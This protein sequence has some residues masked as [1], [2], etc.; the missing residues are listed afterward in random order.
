MNKRIKVLI[1]LALFN[2]SSI[3]VISLISNPVSGQTNGNSL[4]VF[5][6]FSLI[7]Y[8]NFQHEDLDVNLIN[9]SLSSAKWNVKGIELNFSSIK[10][11]EEVVSIEEGGSS[12]KSI[13]KSVK[14]YGVQLNI[15]QDLLLLGVYI[16]GYLDLVPKSPVYVQINGYDAMNH[17]P[18]STIYGN[19]IPIN[20]SSVPNWYLQKFT[21]PISLSKGYYYLV[22]NG[23]GYLPS[24]NSKYNWYLNE[25][26]SIHNFTY[27]SKFDGLSWSIEAQGKPFR[28]KLVQRTEKSFSPEAI[29]MNIEI[30]GSLYNVS[31]GVIPNTGYIKV[32]NVNLALNDSNLMIPISHNQTVSI[33]FNA[34]YNLVLESLLPSYGTS[35]ISTNSDIQWSILPTISREFSNYSV[36]FNFPNNWYNILIKR[37]NIDIT[38]QIEVNQLNH[39]IYIS[40]EAILDD[41]EW[42][43]IAASPKTQIGLIADRVEF[44]PGQEL[45]FFIAPPILSGNYTFILEDPL[46]DMIYNISKL[47]PLGV[48][49]FTY[50]IPSNA[51]DGS[52]KAI[53][54]WHN[55]TDGG[56]ITQEFMVNLPFAIDW[57]LIITISIVIGLVAS[58]SV[59]SI[60]LIK[61]YRQKK[62][63]REQ[64]VT[65]RFMDIINLNYIIVIEKKSS[66]N[67]YD[68]AF[69]EKQ[70]NTTLISGFL[71]AIRTFGIDLSGAS[72]HSQTIKLEY[73]NNKI[74][75]SDY[76]SFRLIFI[77]K[78]L[79]SPQFYKLIDDLSHDIEE[80]FGIY[81]KNFM[82][83]LQPFND[84]EELLKK[85]LGTSFLYPLKIL[86]TGK[87]KIS[88]IEK[89]LISKGVSTMKKKNKDYFYLTDLV[90]GNTLESKEIATLFSLID[91]NVFIPAI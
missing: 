9:I 37:N 7:E 64:E 47:M 45:K 74:L 18:N 30:N 83:N 72:D 51:L 27:T 86:K 91:K 79:P 85:K 77:M 43:I 61:K 28:H 53:V 8:S 60:I 71:E 88:P 78:E 48:N 65:N 90:E 5:K 20:I 81:L 34:T 25:I 19:S 52:Y 4:R 39:Y 36:K 89:A 41:E 2:I 3:Y 1:F 67:V 17:W 46:N 69:T 10:L 35:L 15:T 13:Y 14:G 84:I 42:E 87:A 54:F 6:N 73:H 58:G 68:Q 26:N 33:L 11:G 21:E 31:N 44:L 59:S 76:K 57:S 75:M 56:A 49:S 50:T 63:I 22:L 32:P 38:S 62:I 80:K 12:F 66:L 55:N 24:D 82:G 16:Y 70:F 23:T 29:Q 40:N